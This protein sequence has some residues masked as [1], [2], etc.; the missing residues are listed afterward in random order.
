MKRLEGVV[1]KPATAKPT[2]AAL[3]RLLKSAE[4]EKLR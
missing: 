1:A 3:R 2:A 4:I